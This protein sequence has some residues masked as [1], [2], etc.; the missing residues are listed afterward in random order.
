M[1]MHTIAITITMLSWR[2]DTQAVIIKTD[3]KNR[4]CFLVV[5]AML[6]AI[7]IVRLFVGSKRI[8]VCAYVTIDEKLSWLCDARI[9][10]CAIQGQ[11]L[12]VRRNA[13]S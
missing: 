5:R 13:R 9:I 10:A 11:M 8:Y 7:M 1:Y 2:Y 4:K 3:I 6:F 12:I